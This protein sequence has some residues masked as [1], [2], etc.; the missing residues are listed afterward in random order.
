MARQSERFVCAALKLLHEPEGGTQQ[1]TQDRGKSCP[2]KSTNTIGHLSKRIGLTRADL[3][4]NQ[5]Q[6]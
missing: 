2:L 4:I 6:M 1:W 3:S 5:R